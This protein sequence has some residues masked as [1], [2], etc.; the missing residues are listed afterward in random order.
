M[1]AS[2]SGTF[3]G[4]NSEIE[5]LGNASR[6]KCKLTISLIFLF[7]LLDLQEGEA[8]LAAGAGKFSF[9]TTFS[10]MAVCKPFPK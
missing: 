1:G 4:P 8:S 6:H 2:S 3:T 9:W 7:L 10:E 5:K